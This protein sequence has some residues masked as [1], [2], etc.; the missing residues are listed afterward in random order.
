MAIT[1]K[2][3]N[4]VRPGWAHKIVSAKGLALFAFLAVLVAGVWSWRTLPVDAFPDITPPLVQVFTVTDGLSP[5]EVERYVT[6]PVET[7]MSGLPG[8]E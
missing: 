6:F 2:A 7:A 5:Q 8:L 4:P 3:S 1:T